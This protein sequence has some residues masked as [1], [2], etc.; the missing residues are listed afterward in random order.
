MERRTLKIDEIKIPETRVTSYFDDSVYTEFKNN[1]KAMGVLAPVIV[2]KSGDGYY[3]VDG[4]HRLIEA[5]NNGDEQIKAVVIPGEEKDVFLT[6]LFLNL[7]RGKTKVA[8][9]RKVVE[10]LCKEYGVGLDQ[11]SERTGLSR[12]FVEDLMVISGMPREIVDAFDTGTI[13]KGKVMALAKLP[14]ESEQLSIFYA[15]QGRNLNVRDVVE[16]VE[17][18][19]RVLGE[20]PPSPAQTPKREARYLACDFC[21]SELEPKWMRSALICPDCESALR[22]GL[23]QAEELIQKGPSDSEE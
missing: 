22:T 5:K 6:N 10:L 13:E 15:T 23:R 20:K 7:L 16:V 2:V 3:L 11:I 8:E 18:R 14:S 9:M 12:N 4:L 1:I 19:L 21:E 17:G